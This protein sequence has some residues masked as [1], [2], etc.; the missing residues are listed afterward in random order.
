VR[1]EKKRMRDGDQCFHYDDLETMYEE[2]GLFW[3]LH[4]KWLATQREERTPEPAEPGRTTWQRAT[5]IRLG[6]V[7]NTCNTLTQS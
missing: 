3:K 6:K 1:Q 5:V 7:I 4:Q 2:G